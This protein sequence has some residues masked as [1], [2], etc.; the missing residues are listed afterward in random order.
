VISR[1]A[2][3][4][5]LILAT[6]F[7]VAAAVLHAAHVTAVRVVATAQSTLS[8]QDCSSGAS[9]SV[10][11]RWHGSAVSAQ[12]QSPTCGSGGVMKGES[13]V[14]YV[15]SNEPSNVGPDANWILNPDTHDPFEF[16]GPNGLRGFLTAL[17]VLAIGTAV[18][19]HVGER[20]ARRRA[21]GR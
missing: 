7:L 4:G 18:V 3:V 15:A 1:L 8:T 5:L 2:R 20:R 14:V 17:G 10:Q 9:L 16:I 13:V 19:L 11:F 12:E 6:F 21:D